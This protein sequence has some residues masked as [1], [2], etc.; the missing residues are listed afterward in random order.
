M[1]RHVNKE[2]WQNFRSAQICALLANINR[3]PKQTRAY[4]I[5]DFM[6]GKV[7]HQRQQSPEEMFAIVQQWQAVYE[8]KKNN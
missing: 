3:D 2:D 5:Q 8:Q 7:K 4:E 1:E 6:P